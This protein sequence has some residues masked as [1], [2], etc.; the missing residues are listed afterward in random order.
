MNAGALPIGQAPFALTLLLLCAPLSAWAQT[1]ILG[2]RGY[3]WNQPDHPWPENTLLSA[4]AALA[5]GADGM[6]IDV[7]RSADGVI[8]LRHDDHLHLR[9][10]NG[11]PK[12]DCIGQVSQLDWAHL[13]DCRALSGAP[14]GFSSPLDRLEDLL[15]LE[16]RRL[17]LDVKDDYFCLEPEAAVR[18]IAALVHEAQAVDRVVL[19]LYQP[20]TI[21]LANA[22]GLRS[23]VK[24]HQ[25]W[26]GE[27]M[28]R[29]IIDSGA[30]GACA[31]SRVLNPATMRPLHESGLGQISYL[32]TTTESRTFDQEI[33]ALYALEVTGVITDRIVEAALL[34]ARKVP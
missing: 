23:C 6:E 19:M 12:T 29:E 11:L 15:R 9:D 2:H 18:R 7:L 30:W 22:L 24:Q 3:A 20:R 4:R 21:A 17:V 13:R 1:Q 27:A 25:P 31:Y 28:R 8:V 5:A 14:W 33:L 16:M 10:P 32:L 34:R 26:S